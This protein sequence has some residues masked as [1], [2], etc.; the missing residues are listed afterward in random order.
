M[1]ITLPGVALTL[2]FATSLGLLVAGRRYW[3]GYVARHGT[4]PPNT[5]MFQ[6][7]DDPQLETYRR[8]ALV[9]LP[10]DIVAMVISLMP[11]QP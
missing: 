11:S 9:L 10:V 7:S 4:Q 1:P 2:V 5:W 3:R 6:R 8:V